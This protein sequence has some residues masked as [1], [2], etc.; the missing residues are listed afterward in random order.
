MA[1]RAERAG[2][3]RPRRRPRAAELSAIIALTERHDDLEPLYRRYRDALERTGRTFEMI[4]V[5][6]GPR[7]RALGALERLRSEGEPV[8]IITFARWFGE[9]AALTVGF[10][11]S[12][13]DVVLTLPAY[14]QVEAAEIPRLVDALDDCDMVL[15][16]RSP[17][18][19][20]VINRVQ[21]RVFNWLLR[22]ASDLQVHDAGCGVRVL[23][24]RVLEEVHLYGDLHR[25]LPVL[26]HR[27]GFRVIELDV[28]QSKKDLFQRVYPPG[29]Y[30]RR[31][32]DVLTIFFL[33]KFT[34][35]PLRFFGLL[36]SAV[37][38]AGAAATA[39][40]VVE[41]LFLGVPLAERPALLLAS[42]LV[43]LGIQI[44]AIG[45]LGEI[46]IFT[47]ARGIR[48]YTIERIIE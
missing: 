18:L 27:Q 3:P 5:L 6:D 21:S 43:V 45:L 30:L 29:V 10:E 16:R 1:K 22:G 12:R 36:G 8:V 13:G 20:S 37:F 39:W 26:A 34:K 44:L 2:K 15:A 47:H 23:K 42:L 38:L 28:A 46:I 32:L 17:R 40:V 19:D 24:R 9:A 14:E 11:H 33:V 35:K 4:F 48:E 7:P 25:F 31:L 41:R